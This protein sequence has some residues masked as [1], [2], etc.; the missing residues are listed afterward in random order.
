MS[1]S[2]FRVFFN[3]PTENRQVLDTGERRSNL[4]VLN[5][6]GEVGEV[7]N[8]LLAT[9][10]FML[11]GLACAFQRQTPGEEAEHLARSRSALDF[12]LGFREV[13][14]GAWPPQRYGP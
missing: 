9:L 4:D 6:T 11:S 1:P 7:N 8:M 5:I 13:L 2:K 10:R 14:P 3:E 12:A